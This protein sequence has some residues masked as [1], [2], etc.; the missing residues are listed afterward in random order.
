[1]P[2]VLDV[3]LMIRML[4]RMLGIITLSDANIVGANGLKA[5][6]RV[7]QK[8]TKHRPSNV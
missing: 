7:W 8:K 4:L 3:I 1:M 5:G 6:V 2:S